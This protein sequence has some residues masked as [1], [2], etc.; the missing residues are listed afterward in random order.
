LPESTTRQPVAFGSSELRRKVFRKRLTNFPNSPAEASIAKIAAS[1]TIDRIEVRCRLQAF[2]LA[3]GAHPH[4]S[5][6]LRVVRKAGGTMMDA[7]SAFI[8][9]D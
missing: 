3:L 7:K 9:V 1:A 2:H 5:E 8:P 6:K 4:T